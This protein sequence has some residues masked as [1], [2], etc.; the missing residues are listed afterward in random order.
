MGVILVIAADSALRRS[1]KFALEAEAFAVDAYER[2]D[3]ARRSRQFQEAICAV[4]DE[5][6]LDRGGA[7][8]AL[9]RFAKPVILL[10][11]RSPSCAA[12]DETAV[13]V[14][15]LHLDA[16]IR[17]VREMTRRAHQPGAE[18]AVLDPI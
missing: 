7:A 10:V 9:K 18:G 17:T 5:D 6:G 15:P 16:L 14:K 1:L 2:L 12:H 13:L 8:A 11:D 3:A 4:V